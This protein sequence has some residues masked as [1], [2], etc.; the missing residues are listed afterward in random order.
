MKTGL[1][2]FIKT[3]IVLFIIFFPLSMAIVKHGIKPNLITTIIVC[4]GMITSVA[5]IILITIAI[6][7]LTFILFNDI[8]KHI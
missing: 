2:N 1:S 5:M 7:K 6:I 3:I 8:I 4:I